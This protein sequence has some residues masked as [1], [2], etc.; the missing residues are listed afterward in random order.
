GPTGT[1]GTNG[2][3][4]ATG[5]TGATG[6]AGASPFSVN[7]TSAYYNSGNVGLG[8]TSPSA[9][10]DVEGG[11]GSFPYG[12]SGVILDPALNNAGYGG[13]TYI[14]VNIQPTVYGGG[15]GETLYGLQVNP[16]FATGFN[17]S[18]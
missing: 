2:T 5:A 13:A 9:A 7:G 18:N 10:L 15:G 16:S 6:A 1:A 12:G 11:I 4:G 8:T 14:G 3:N 17:G